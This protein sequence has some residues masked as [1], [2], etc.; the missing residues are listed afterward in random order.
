MKLN[1][2]VSIGALQPRR[3]AVALRPLED[4]VD[5][6]RIMNIPQAESRLR[7][8]LFRSS[9]YKIKVTNV[10]EPKYLRECFI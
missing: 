7:T 2:T 6:E 5:Q 9:V 1:P 4:L 10:N 8:F 3:I